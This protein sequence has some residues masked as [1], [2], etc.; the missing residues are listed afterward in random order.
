MD[1]K[2]AMTVGIVRTQWAGTSGGPGLTQLAIAEDTGGFWTATQAQ[3]AVN[4]VRAFWNS[5]ATYMPD[6][7]VLTVSPVVDLYRETDNELIASEVA[8]TAPTSVVG[9]STAIFSMASGMKVNLNT[10]TIR[11]GRRVRGAIYVV[12]AGSNAYTTGGAVASAVRTAVN[13]AGATL[14]S[15]LNSSGL[16]LVVWSRGRD[17][18]TPKVG[19]ISDVTSLEVNEKVAILRGR[20]D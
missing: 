13:T 19:A 16:K 1:G 2:D 15:T 8:P 7:V 10:T 5:V 14:D 20:R 11:G 9:L 12:P 18:P 6:E 17:L 3:N 4:A